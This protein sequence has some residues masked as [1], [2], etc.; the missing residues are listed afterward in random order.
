[1]NLILKYLTLSNT[2]LILIIVLL[3]THI[4]SLI[5]D[6]KNNIFKYIFNMK[7]NNSNSNNNN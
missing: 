3:F 4:I 6:N 5:N 1:M 7:N 2:Y